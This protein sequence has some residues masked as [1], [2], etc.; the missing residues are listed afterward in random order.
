M[1]FSELYP[2]LS[3]HWPGLNAPNIVRSPAHN[4]TDWLD[5]SNFAWRNDNA[6]YLHTDKIN[7]S[8]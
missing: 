8:K 3:R 4:S 7:D 5:Y 1:K 6:A 2:I